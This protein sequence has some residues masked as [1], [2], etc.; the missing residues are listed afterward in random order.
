MKQPPRVVF[1]TCGV[2]PVLTAEVA[3]FR[4]AGWR[5]AAVDPT[6]P[7]DDPPDPTGPDPV[8]LL[9]VRSMEGL[10]HAAPDL[11]SLTATRCLIAPDDEVPG[12]ENPAI[13]IRVADALA[14][15]LA[16]HRP[17]WCPAA[18]GF[19]ALLAQTSGGLDRAAGSWPFVLAAQDAAVRTHDPPATRLGLVALAPGEPN[20]ALDRVIEAANRAG[21]AVRCLVRAEAFSTSAARWG[22]SATVFS[23]QE[24]SPGWFLEGVELL[25]AARSSLRLRAVR[26]IVVQAAG[27]GVLPLIAGPAADEPGLAA[28]LG[29]PLADGT[30]QATLDRLV[31]D[32]RHWASQ[33]GAAR[34]RALS[35]AGPEAFVGR[36]AAMAGL[37]QAARGSPESPWRGRFG[38]LIRRHAGPTPAPTPGLLF[39]CS[40]G[41]GLG[42]VA[43]SLAIAQACRPWASVA[44]FSLSAALPAIRPFG[45]PVEHFPTAEYLA[46]ADDAWNRHLE[47]ALSSL[48]VERGI[49]AIV[50]DGNRLH[51][52]LIRAAQATGC[53]L[54]WV[55]RGLWQAGHHARHL[56][57]Q[58]FCDLVIVPGDLAAGRDRGP[59]A[60]DGTAP[61]RI[62][63]VPPIVL[64][65]PEGR[66]PRAEARRALGLPTDGPAA[67]VQLGAGT[68]VDRAD[69]L[70][71]VLDSLDR[72]GV[73]AR[74]AVWPMPDPA[75]DRLRRRLAAEGRRLADR[76]PLSAWH[77]AFD[78][79]IASAGYN[80][81]HE[82]VAAR[83][84]T[85]FLPI[86]APSL[87]D[88]PARA[89]EARDAGF[90]HWIESPAAAT[91]DAAI[92]RLLDPQE[93]H[94]L[95]A[96]MPRLAPH[97]GARA[98]ATAIRAL[99]R[100]PAPG[101]FPG[102]FDTAAARSR[103]AVP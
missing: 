98:A 15:R 18:D 56:V 30:E 51:P 21:L 59:A 55:R 26:D 86:E 3:A 91:V 69:V 5:T 63:T 32:R 68:L 101:R 74:I 81:F 14:R 25:V 7:S 92:G 83:L 29:C 67:L 100:A 20:P 82:A 33:V 49:R 53:R 28:T 96:A 44:L 6:G 4:L 19:D 71:A 42:H 90:G 50:Y 87:D 34:R 76:F 70:A 35:L 94:R 27:R 65:P 62:V 52:G 66:R 10:I 16:R 36:V 102:R 72:Q 17:V 31:R 38:S 80:V 40:N 24:V 61:A 54:A 37:P 8:E 75:I 57:P 58:K 23:R 13:R 103:E 95:I 22:A 79:S 47:S 85:A 45:F 2:S 88:Q 93:R 46:V 78:F 41:I 48:C 73:A 11:Q 99:V 60:P 9:L 12:W 43:R 89:A 64:E 97:A 39:V 77:A 84:P 1:V